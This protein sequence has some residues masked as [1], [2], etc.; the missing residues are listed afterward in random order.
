MSTSTQRMMRPLLVTAMTAAMVA[1]VTLSS[2][3]SRGLKPEVHKPSKL[4]KISAPVQA[5]S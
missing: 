4:P 3:C 5:V 2:G 1:S